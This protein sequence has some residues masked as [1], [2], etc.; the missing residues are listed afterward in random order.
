MKFKFTKQFVLSLAFLLASAVAFAQLRTPVEIANEHVQSQYAAWGLTAQDVDGM[1]VSDQYTDPT[2]G[3]SRVFFIQRHQGIPVYNA[4]QNISISKDGKVFHVGRRFVPNLASKV[5][6]TVPVL[7]AE[8]AVVK[9]MQ[10]LQIPYAPLRPIGQNDQGDFVFEKGNIAK[11]DIKARL[12]YQQYGSV[13]L[14]S[15]DISLAPTHSSDMWSARVDAVTGD[16]LDQVN[17]TVYCKVD[18]SAFAHTDKD[19]EATA[20]H[21]HE[22]VTT[23]FNMAADGT[24]NVWPWPI[25]SPKHGPRSMVIDPHDLTASPYGWHDTNGAAGPEYTITRGNNVHAYEDSGDTDASIDNEPDG[26]ASLVFDFPYDALAEPV[27]FTNAAI[28]NLFYWNNIMHDLSYSYGMT[29]SAG[30]FQA[31]NYGNGGAGNDFVNAEGQDGG[32]TNNANFSTPPDGGNGRMQM[33]LWSA[34]SAGEV[35]NVDEPASVAG[36]YPSSQPA[37]GWG[38]GAYAT[39]AG[40]TADVVIVEDAL[41]NDLFS[42]ACEEIINAADLVDQDCIDRPWRL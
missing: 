35:F 7:D 26:G 10:H 11:Q 27:T 18:G 1:T 20:N 42:D 6:T 40:V 9:L 17:W 41:A 3:I 30:A 33:Y 2:T 16:L 8:A 39:M 34:G 22:A 13:V 25:E 19:C 21:N 14:L 37:T 38:T 12:S 15:W 24:Y 5:N 36:P 32:G 29:E 23:S 4:I 28:V 31:H